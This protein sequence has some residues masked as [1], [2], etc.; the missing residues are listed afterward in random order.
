MIYWPSCHSEYV[1]LAY[2]C[3]G[4]IMVSGHEN[5]LPT[6][7][8]YVLWCST[9]KS[10]SLWMTWGLVN[11][12]GELSFFNYLL[13]SYTLT[14][15]FSSRKTGKCCCIAC[16]VNFTNAC[17]AVI[18]HACAVISLVHIKNTS[19]S[20]LWL[21][22]IQQRKRWKRRVMERTVPFDSDYITYNSPFRVKQMLHGWF[23]LTSS[24]WW[25]I[26]SSSDT[27]FSNTFSFYGME[28]FLML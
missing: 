8:K 23:L 9:C 20:S 3:M 13:G 11:D 27:F 5:W 18:Q 19:K 16:M 10:C 7:S 2:F 12:L 25:T 1:W 21:K 26:I 24:V 17:W 4:N 14:W 15:W 22:F 6:F 28:N